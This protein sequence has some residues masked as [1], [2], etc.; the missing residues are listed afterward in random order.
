MLTEMH[1]AQQDMAE[2]EKVKNITLLT[3]P[4]SIEKGE[5]TNTQ[6]IRRAV[7]SNNYADH[8]AAMYPDERLEE[9]L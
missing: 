2:Y 3:E 4:F 5:I 8:I 7:I 6:K 9:E 1:I